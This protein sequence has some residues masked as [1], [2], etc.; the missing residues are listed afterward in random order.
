MH[1]RPWTFTPYVYVFYVVW[2]CVCG[3][4]KRPQKSSHARL[5][6]KTADH[7]EKLSYLFHCYAFCVFVLVSVTDLSACSISIPLC[8]RWITIIV[9]MI[10]DSFSQWDKDSNLT[11]LN[12]QWWHFWFFMRFELQ[13]NAT[14]GYYLSDSVYATTATTRFPS[15]GLLGK[16]VDGVWLKNKKCAIFLIPRNDVADRASLAEHQW[17]GSKHI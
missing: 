2:W 9:C 5:A 12:R 1:A 10:V 3:V 7:C 11:S 17:I 6:S 15:I 14:I 4:R 13:M 16:S 8:S